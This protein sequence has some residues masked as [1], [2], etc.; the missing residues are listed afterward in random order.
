MPR[1]RARLTLDSGIKVDLSRLPLRGRGP[2]RARWHWTFRTGDEL[3]V[4]LQFAEA[5]GQLT[6]THDEGVQ[7]FALRALPRHF[8]GQQWFVVCPQTARL[9]RVLR[10]PDG[11]RWFRTRHGFGRRAGYQSQFLDESGRAWR[12]QARI[13]S[14]LI[15]DLDPNDWDLPP[16]PKWMRWST[17]RRLEARFD[18]AEE[19]LDY[20]AVVAAARLLKIGWPS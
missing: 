11:A 6:V 15:G 9:A 2:Y 5:T 18:R 8:G 14:R 7:H 4:G 17:Y 16:K 20:Q 10:R 3:T 1:P 12:A 19:F 13:K